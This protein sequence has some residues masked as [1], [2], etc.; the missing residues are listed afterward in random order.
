VCVQR[1]KQNIFKDKNISVKLSNEKY[2]ATNKPKT[3]KNN[4]RA[5]VI[6]R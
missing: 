2:K 1:Q 5:L 4:G 6:V 3:Q